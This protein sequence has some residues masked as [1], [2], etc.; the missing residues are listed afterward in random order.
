MTSLPRPAR[1][2]QFG[3]LKQLTELADVLQALIAAERQIDPDDLEDMMIWAAMHFWGLSFY[4]AKQKIADVSGG[5]ERLHRAVVIARD[6]LRR[7]LSEQAN[8]RGRH[9]RK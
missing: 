4:A 7:K 8:H 1:L 2:S 3:Q 5:T 9:G 6:D